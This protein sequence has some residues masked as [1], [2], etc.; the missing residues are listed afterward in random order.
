VV[1]NLLS[2]FA[3]WN[4]MNAPEN[5]ENPAGERQGKYTAS[6]GHAE[7][8]LPGFTYDSILPTSRDRS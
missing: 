2:L 4:V 1:S 6:T 8:R 3:G 5:A 7:S